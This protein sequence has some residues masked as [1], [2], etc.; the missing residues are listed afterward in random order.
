MWRRVS[1]YIVADLAEKQS[2]YTFC[3]ELS[4]C[5]YTLE[6]EMADPSEAL[7]L[8]YKTTRRHIPENV[9]SQSACD[10]EYSRRDVRK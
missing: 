2:A 9:Q 7:V 3:M 4:D 10:T 5:L 8:V 1:W 6:M